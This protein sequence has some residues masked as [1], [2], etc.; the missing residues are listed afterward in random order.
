MNHRP[1]QKQYLQ[2][3]TIKH[4]LIPDVIANVSVNIYQ[5]NLSDRDKFGKII[6]KGSGGGGGGK[7]FQSSSRKI[8]KGKHPQAV[9]YSQTYI[10]RYK[11]RYNM[12]EWN[13]V[14]KMKQFIQKTCTTRKSI[15]ILINV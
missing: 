2:K 13:I 9:M 1:L 4:Q 6:Y 12:W 14:Y 3:H 15:R 8:K 10:K 7:C 11:K 5:I